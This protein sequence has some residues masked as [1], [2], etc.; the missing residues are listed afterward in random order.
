MTKEFKPKTDKCPICDTKWTVTS[1]GANV[2]Y[3]CKPC[4]KTAEDIVVLKSSSPSGTK[5]YRLGSI[6]EWEDF[7]SQID[8]DYDIDDWDGTF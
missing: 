8:F 4:G 1:F 7:I 5:E 2:W 3:D 6:E